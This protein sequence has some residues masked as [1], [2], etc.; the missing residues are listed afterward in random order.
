[1]DIE[2]LRTST[3]LDRVKEEEDDVKWGKLL[4]EIHERTPFAD[5]YYL[6]EELENKVDEQGKKI[7]DLETNLKTHAH[8]NGKAVKEI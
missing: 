5:I 1:M 8:L 3:L 4:D 7:K 2:K 6:F